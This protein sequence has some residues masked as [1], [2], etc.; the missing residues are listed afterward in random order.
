MAQYRR[1]REW[2]VVGESAALIMMSALQFIFYCHDRLAG[3]VCGAL[4]LLVRNVRWW[5]GVCDVDGR[6]APLGE[7]T[8]SCSFQVCSA[9][10]QCGWVATGTLGALALMVRIDARVDNLWNPALPFPV[11]PTTQDGPST[12]D[13]SRRSSWAFGAGGLCQ[14]LAHKDSSTF[15]LLRA[16]NACSGGSSSELCRWMTVDG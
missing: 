9:H 1:E 14:I 12:Q 7:E 15:W 8:C 4:M 6:Q 5:V 10:Q 3:G 2:F 11:V 16:F 13:M